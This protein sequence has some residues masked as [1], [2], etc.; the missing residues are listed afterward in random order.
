MKFEGG[1]RTTAISTQYLELP[2]MHHSKRQPATAMQQH[3]L[4]VLGKHKG[5][6]GLTVKAVDT[7]GWTCKLDDHHRHICLSNDSLHATEGPDEE[8]IVP[9]FEPVVLTAE[10][11]QLADVPTWLQEYQFDADAPVDLRRI[12]PDSELWLDVL[13]R[14]RSIASLS[15]DEVL[16]LRYNATGGCGSK[17]QQPHAEHTSSQPLTCYCTAG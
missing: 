1:T 9:A 10:P 6:H 15:D 11:L 5:E 14:Q 3:I 12:K 17:H 13:T 4:V 16:R 7:S 2:L 8:H